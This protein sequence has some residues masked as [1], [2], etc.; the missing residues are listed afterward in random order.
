MKRN[1]K[2]RKAQVK[3]EKRKM[4][5][6]AEKTN[7]KNEAPMTG[8]LKLYC[9]LRYYQYGLGKIRFDAGFHAT[10]NLAE[11]R[12]IERAGDYG[13]TTHD[14]TDLIRKMPLSEGAKIYLSI[15]PS[16]SIVE[17]ISRPI[18]FQPFSESLGV[19]VTAEPEPQWAI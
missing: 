9:N 2:R 12:A 10:A 14:I 4:E 11:Q 7:G 19:Y 13:L 5:T 15:D 18:R 17:N 8:E 1:Q 6:A 16:L 3:K